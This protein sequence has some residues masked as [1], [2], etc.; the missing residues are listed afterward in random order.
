[1]VVNHSSP[2]HTVLFA[3][4]Y[5]LR[6]HVIV[7]S[8]CDDG[9]ERMVKQ[10]DTLARCF[11]TRSTDQRQEPQMEVANFDDVNE[12]RHCVPLIRR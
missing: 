8:D 2:S 12:Q 11:V 6:L 5:L 9:A 7:D 4:E 1:M 3:V 10:A